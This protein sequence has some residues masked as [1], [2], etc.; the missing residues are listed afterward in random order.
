MHLS[1]VP[2]DQITKDDVSTP[3][4]CTHTSLPLDGM[5]RNALFISMDMQDH[6]IYQ[7]WSHFYPTSLYLMRRRKSIWSLLEWNPGPLASQLTALTSRPCLLGHN[8]GWINQ[9][10]HFQRGWT[11]PFKPTSRFSE[12]RNNFGCKNDDYFLALSLTDAYEYVEELMIINQAGKLTNMR[13]ICI[14]V[15]SA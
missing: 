7:V 10:D 6:A 12:F 15:M 13:E 11:L 1:S 14:F 3:I 8:D 4:P 5:A 2:F 9:A